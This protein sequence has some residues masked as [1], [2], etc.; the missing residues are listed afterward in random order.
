MKIYRLKNALIFP[1]ID[2][3]VY[4][5]SSIL[6]VQ[7][8]HYKND[9]N[10]FGLMSFSNCHTSNSLRKAY[11][12]R[13]APK[14]MYGHYLYLGHLNHHFGH[15]MEECLGRLWACE[16]YQSEVD[17]FI[18]IV[19]NE[20]IVLKPFM[21][22]IFLLF[23]IDISKIKLVSELVEVENLIVPELGSWFGGEKKWF[24]RVIKKYIH[25]E[26]YKKVLPKK[27]IVRRSSKFLG[28]VAGFNY[29][30]NILVSKGFT[31]IFPEKYSLEE[32]IAFVISAEIIVWEQGSA[33]HLL[34]I[35]P[36]LKGT[37]ILIRRDLNSPAIENL[38]KNKFDRVSIYRDVEGIFLP[39]KWYANK[40]M[41]NA[42]MATFKHPKKILTF[43]K[44]NNLIDEFKFEEI[45]FKKIEKKD[46]LYFYINYFLVTFLIKFIKPILPKFVWLK[47]KVI[48]DYFFGQR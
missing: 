1:A 31:E 27:I 33:C 6:G 9:P 19:T 25:L 2:Q 7:S 42:I 26:N 11:L 24:R 32:Q 39:N 34:K 48:K 35:L 14:K 20:N 4:F 21:L 46:L 22:E 10:E 23:N 13:N 43:F 17:S 16:K 47:L 12:K 29:F 37:S 3:A 28:R 40:N 41:G 30:S 18:F 8:E 5:K 45:I 15:F 36:K 38:I 44:K